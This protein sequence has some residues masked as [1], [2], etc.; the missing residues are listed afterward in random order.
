MAVQV[1]RQRGFLMEPSFTASDMC[2]SLLPTERPMRF[3][4]SRIHESG[5]SMRLTT[6]AA[7]ST[8]S[9]IRNVT[10]QNASS[11]F[12]AVFSVIAH[13]L[14]EGCSAG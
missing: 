3:L 2:I 10:T 11:M 1:F 5:L 12:L 7:A 8:G 4:S 14:P 13:L 6:T 9:T